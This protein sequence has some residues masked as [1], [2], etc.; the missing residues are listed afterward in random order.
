LLDLKSVLSAFKVIFNFIYIVYISLYLAYKLSFF[1]IPLLNL[2]L[3]VIFIARDYYII[4]IE[5]VV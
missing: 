4:N 2:L 1:L 5:I 3:N